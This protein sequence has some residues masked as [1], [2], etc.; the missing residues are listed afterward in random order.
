MRCSLDPPKVAGDLLLPKM[1]TE[2]W[3]EVLT[4]LML[5]REIGARA[6]SERSPLLTAGV[7]SEHPARSLESKIAEHRR[8]PTEE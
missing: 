4:I 8:R 3:K 2:D 6:Q 7:G 5:E 1:L